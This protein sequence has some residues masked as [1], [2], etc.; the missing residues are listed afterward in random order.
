MSWEQAATGWLERAAVMELSPSPPG[1]RRAPALFRCPDHQA[2]P[3]CCR[4]TRHGHT[5]G[6]DARPGGRCSLSPSL[7]AAAGESIHGLTSLQLLRFP[8]SCKCLALP[9][10][11][12]RGR[13]GLGG[14]VG[15][16]AGGLP[17]SLPTLAPWSREGHVQQSRSSQVP[18]FTQSHLARDVL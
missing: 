14:H 11:P 16:Q 15:D 1:R 12:M 2:D 7:W 10:Q 3:N 18:T 6:T 5:A 9:T 8:Q 4:Q 13:E 17:T